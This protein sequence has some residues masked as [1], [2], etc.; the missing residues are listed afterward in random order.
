MIYGTKQLKNGKIKGSL[1]FSSGKMLKMNEKEN[2]EFQVR[3]FLWQKEAIN[4]GETTQKITN[5]HK[6]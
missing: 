6:I 3:V 4:R 5:I 2:Q 1:V